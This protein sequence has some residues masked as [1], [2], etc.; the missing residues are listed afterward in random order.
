[1]D[2]FSHSNDEQT[3]QILINAG[4]DVNH[5]NVLG[6]TPLE[7]AATVG[8]CRV[9]RL[10]V[11]HPN[12]QLDSQV[13]GSAL[14]LFLHRILHCPVLISRERMNWHLLRT[15]DKSCN[16]LSCFSTITVCN[17][18]QNFVIVFLMRDF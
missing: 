9:L 2:Y 15:L 10:L 7:V 16:S 1:M 8:H 18:S 13:N 5:K 4:A 12:I 14:S 6:F 11:K 3:V 17:Q